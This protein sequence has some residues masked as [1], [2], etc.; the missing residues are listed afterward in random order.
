[1]PGAVLH[2][3]LEGDWVRGGQSAGSSWMQNKGGWRGGSKVWRP[4]L[5]RGLLMRLHQVIVYSMYLVAH[6]QAPCQ[7]LC[8]SLGR[9]PPACLLP[10]VRLVPWCM[11]VVLQ[12]QGGGAGAGEGG[13]GAPVRQGGQGSAGQSLVG[14]ISLS[15]SPCV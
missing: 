6:Q 9:A 5:E 1:M 8:S 13:R 10:D 2:T 3:E 11:G 15:S 4:H 14:S 7:E 12:S